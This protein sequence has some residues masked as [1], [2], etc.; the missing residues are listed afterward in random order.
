MP[1]LTFRVSTNF[2]LANCLAYNA[3]QSSEEIE[4]MADV[5][6][7]RVA[8]SFLVFYDDEVAPSRESS[9]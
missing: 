4:K 5:E 1:A 9:P 6:A 2:A 3:G 8:K 7:V